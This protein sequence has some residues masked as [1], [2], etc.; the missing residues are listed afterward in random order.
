MAGVMETLLFILAKIH[1]TTLMT[2]DSKL[3]EIVGKADL[4]KYVAWLADYLVAI[5]KA[6][7]PWRER[8][9][10]RGIKIEGFDIPG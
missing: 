2:T 10:V 3:V 4:K 7:L 9:G 5:R 1:E 6:P 8:V